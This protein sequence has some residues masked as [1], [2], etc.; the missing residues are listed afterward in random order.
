MEFYVEHTRDCK[1][2]SHKNYLVDANVWIE[3]LSPR[4]DSG[5][6]QLNAVDFFYKIRSSPSRVVVT[7]TVLGEVINR[8]IRIN[9]GKWKIKHNKD[10]SNFDIKRTYQM[11]PEYKEDLKIL[12]DDIASYKKGIDFVSDSFNEINPV[13][14]LDE[15]NH[16]MEFNDYLY[17]QIAKK[18][19]YAILTIDGD[20]LEEGVKIVTPNQVLVRAAKDKNIESLLNIA[21]N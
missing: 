2:S 9:F 11:H 1:V 5:N 13:E 21:K 14:M 15:C 6:A 16:K 17:I 7:S 8:I 3:L 12:Y 4:S 18:N 10:K 20:F 19:D